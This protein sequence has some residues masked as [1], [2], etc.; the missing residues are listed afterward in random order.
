MINLELLTKYSHEK[1][2]YSEKVIVSQFEEYENEIGVHYE[3]LAEDYGYF[4]EMFGFYV[5]I[6]KKDYFIWMI[7][8][9]EDK[10]EQLLKDNEA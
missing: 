6:N 3:Y 9:R 8:R 7:E 10:I 5:M 4:G 1:F 2:R